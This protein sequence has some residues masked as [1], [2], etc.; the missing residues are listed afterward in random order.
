[1]NFVVQ[2]LQAA[3]VGGVRNPLLLLLGT[4]GFV[5]LIACANVAKLQLTVLSP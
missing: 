1:V 4:V 3:I 2:P 5:L